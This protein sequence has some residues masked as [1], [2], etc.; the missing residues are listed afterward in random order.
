MQDGEG[1]AMATDGDAGDHEVLQQHH[2]QPGLQQYMH[3][4]QHQ[5]GGMVELDLHAMA[6]AGALC[7][8][9]RLD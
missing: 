2:H 9:T 6:L 5:G 7:C 8:K 3:P 1:E 4:G